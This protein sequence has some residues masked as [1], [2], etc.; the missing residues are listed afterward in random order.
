M[1]VF[2]EHVHCSSFLSTRK[3]PDAAV[4]FLPHE[5]RSA[6]CGMAGV[7][8]AKPF[9]RIVATRSYHPATILR[10]VEVGKRKNIRNGRCWMV[11]NVL[12]FLGHY[13]IQVE[14]I[15]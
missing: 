10:I 9:G 7:Q 13:E 2:P 4:P 15:Q 6:E 5:K 8:R 11:M 12:Y 1:S 14:N 3:C